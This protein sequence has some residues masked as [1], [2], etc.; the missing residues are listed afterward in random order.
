MIK[1]SATFI[2]THFVRINTAILLLLVAYAMLRSYFAMSDHWKYWEHSALWAFL[3][4]NIFL[5]WTG[6]S[7]NNS[8]TIAIKN[9]YNLG[10][11]LILGFTAIFV[12]GAFYF[13][14][15]SFIHLLFISL[16]SLAL[17]WVDYLV[18]A[19]AKSRILSSSCAIEIRRLH[20]IKDEFE[21]TFYFSDWPN[22]IGFL[23]LAFTVGIQYQALPRTTLVIYEKFIGGAIAFQLIASVVIFLIIR[24]GYNRQ[25]L[26]IPSMP[27]QGIPSLTEKKKK[28]RSV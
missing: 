6:L 2:D 12:I 25:E 20:N 22:S 13:L 18:I 16:I 10:V 21:K 9:N 28:K 19:G 23:I 5:V 1:K 27:A 17:F 24:G 8:W 15:N 4:F 3:L 11:G 14:D 7:E 26:Q